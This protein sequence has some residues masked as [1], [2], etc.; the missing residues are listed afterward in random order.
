MRMSFSTRPSARRALGVAG[1]AAAVAGSSL[2]ALP[3]ADA[4]GDPITVTLRHGVLTVRGND[5]ANNISVVRTAGGRIVVRADAHVERRG[6]TARIG[7]VRVIRVVARSG[8]D[9]VRL[10][11]GLPRATI[12]GG[13]GN[14]HLIGGAVAETLRGGAGHDDL[15]GGDGADRILGGTGN[16]IED[17]QAG[18]DLLVGGAGNDSLVGQAGDDTLRGETGDDTYT[19]DPLIQQGSDVAQESVG[20]GMDT[21]S[22]STTEGVTFTLDSAAPQAVDTSLTITLSAADVFEGLHGG[23]GDDTLTGNALPNRING[24]AGDDQITGGAGADSIVPGDGFG[25]FMDDEFFAVPFGHDTLDDF[26]Q[27]DTVDVLPGE[28]VTAGLGTS[29]VSLSSSRD[30]GSLTANGHIFDD[31]DFE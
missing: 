19:F 6:K 27:E 26:S 10:Y 4:A 5:R 20:G 2:L 22:F 3:P 8:N 30:F 18:D 25:D 9:T 17:G 23:R 24:G 31:G 15:V 1:V 21:I 13:A 12:L 29:T 11:P 14:D 16:D 28:K 7:S